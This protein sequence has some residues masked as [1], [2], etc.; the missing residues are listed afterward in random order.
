[1]LSSFFCV[2]SQDAMVVILK[3]LFPACLFNIVGFGSKFKTLFAT[4]RS[5]NEVSNPQGP[6]LTAIIRSAVTVQ[7]IKARVFLP[8]SS[9]KG[10]GLYNERLVEFHTDFIIDKNTA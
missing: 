2:R 10:L 9:G 7:R 6:A 3:S 1:M 4:S 5:Y 8:G